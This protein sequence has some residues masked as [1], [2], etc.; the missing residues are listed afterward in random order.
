MYTLTILVVSSIHNMMA[1][2]I[3]Y[4]HG[5]NIIIL[6]NFILVLILVASNKLYSAL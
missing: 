2:V 4:Y 3:N 1:R 6:I 5:D